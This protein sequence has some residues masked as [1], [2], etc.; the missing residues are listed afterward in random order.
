MLPRPDD[1]GLNGDVTQGLAGFQAVDAFDQDV[2]ILALAHLDRQI[3][4]PVHDAFGDLLGLGGVQFLAAVRR[5][6]DICDFNVNGFQQNG[7]PVQSDLR[8]PLYRYRAIRT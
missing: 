6:V 4:D 1:I 5:D 7:F 8:R 3:F 2:A